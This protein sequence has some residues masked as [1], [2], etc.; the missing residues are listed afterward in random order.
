MK[1]ASNFF[2]L[3][4]F[5]AV[6]TFSCH[7]SAALHTY[8]FEG[9]VDIISDNPVDMLADISVGD[10]FTGKF[11]LD[12]SKN[13]PTSNPHD[14]LIWFMEAV[15]YVDITYYTASAGE[16]TFISAGPDNAL[17]QADLPEDPHFG[18]P[19]QHHK[20][21][22]GANAISSPG[23]NLWVRVALN[24][25]SREL[26]GDPSVL[27]PG[28]PPLSEIDWAVGWVR[29]LDSSTS[30][31]TNIFGDLTR[32]EAVIPIPAAAWLFGSALIGLV[33]VAKRKK[34]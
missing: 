15:P 14:L 3:S 6:V 17:I 12:D 16:I 29:Y 21:F 33:G 9:F 8:V 30:R 4:L 34:A 1:R 7:V 27:E 26:F 20:M 23:E 2:R 19:P 28:I 22:A 25:F 31:D 5:W 32:L 24:D 13:I 11:I 18:E 10:R